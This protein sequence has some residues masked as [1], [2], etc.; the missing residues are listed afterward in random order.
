MPKEYRHFSH[1]YA[2][3]AHRSQGK[4]VDVVIISA[5][6]MTRELFYVA[7]SRGRQG[8][9]V[10]TSDKERLLESIGR[11]TARK[12]ASELARGI[13]QGL[14]QGPSRGI[15]AARRLALWNATQPDRIPQ[16]PQTIQPTIQPPP[17]P[18]EEIYYGRQL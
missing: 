2:V 17:T 15:E 14:R 3:T 7:V 1:G 4:T 16:A 12:S 5:D 6:D 13:S 18:K 10:V 9:S 8:L 11:S